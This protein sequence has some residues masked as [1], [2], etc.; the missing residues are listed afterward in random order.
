[1]EAF[2]SEVLREVEVKANDAFSVKITE[3]KKNNGVTRMAILAT[4]PGERGGASIYL[5]GYYER[6]GAG[7]MEIDGIAEDICRQIIRHRDDLKDGDLEGLWDWE[8]MRPHIRAKLV[9]RKMNRELLRRAPHR[10]FL[11]LA[12]VYYAEVFGLPERDKGAIVVLDKYMERWG[13]DEE[14]L[15]QTACAN[16]RLAGVPV[17]EGMDKIL[18]GMIPEPMLPF[19]DADSVISMYVLTNQDKVFGAAEILDSGT[20][21]EISDRLGGDYIVLPSSVH[22]SIIIPAE[23]AASYQELSAIVEGVNRDA[24]SM[25]EMLSDHVYLYDRNE[26]VLKIA[27]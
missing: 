3:N 20:L 2:V 5:D 6:Y 25:E 16:M 24:V 26:G 4:A 19:A 11:D 21:K 22:E 10:K 27:A 9:N 15:Y 7:E 17:F 14:S 13:Q 1:M 18:R 8:L 23:G 12:V